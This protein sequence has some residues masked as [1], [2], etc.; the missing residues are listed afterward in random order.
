M[1]REPETLESLCKGAALAAGE[2]KDP[3]TWGPVLTTAGLNM[4]LPA[5]TEMRGIPPPPPKA[6]SL[7]P[8]SSLLMGCPAEIPDAISLEVTLMEKYGF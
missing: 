2:S 1:G 7:S 3:V 6:Q 8:I 5:D 4:L